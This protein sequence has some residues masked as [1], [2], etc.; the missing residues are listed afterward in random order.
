M[1]ASRMRHGRPIL[2][3]GTGKRINVSGLARPATLTL[4]QLSPIPTG[5][6]GMAQ[7]LIRADCQAQLDVLVDTFSARSEG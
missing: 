2:P 3:C 4:R 1:P 7:S 5:L 6:E